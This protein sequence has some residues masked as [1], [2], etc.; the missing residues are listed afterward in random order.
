MGDPDRRVG[1]VDMLP[2]GAGR[3]IRVDAQILRVDHH[4]TLVGALQLRHHLDQR[5]RGVAAV[6]LVE[7]RDADKPVHAVLRTHQPVCARAAHDEG[8]ALQPRL[9]PG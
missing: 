2:A 7:R 1:L 3:P 9:F 5:E 8:D 4:R 6:V